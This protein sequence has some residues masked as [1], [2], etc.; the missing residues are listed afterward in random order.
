[1]HGFVIS[2]VSCI[3]QPK[4]IIVAHYISTKT[5]DH[6]DGLY[7]SY[8][9]WNSKTD[10]KF[11]HGHLLQI[12]MVFSCVDLSEDG[13]VLDLDDLGEIRSWIK[14]MF[15]H[16]ICIDRDDPYREV[17]SHL[18]TAQLAKIRYL[19]GVGCENFAR[20]I[21]YKIDKWME[22]TELKPRVFIRTVEVIESPGQSGFYIG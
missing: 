13:Q 7:C 19:D 15:G 5:F 8:R 9:K 16:T 22:E 10:K 14:D 18:E 17:F 1:M 4:R 2:I 3:G 21:W 11:I 20:I 6:N 12:K